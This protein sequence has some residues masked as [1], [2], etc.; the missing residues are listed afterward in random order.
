[1]EAMALIVMPLIG[2]LMALSGADLTDRKLIT[3]QEEEE[4]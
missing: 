3:R 4:K 2:I 1:M